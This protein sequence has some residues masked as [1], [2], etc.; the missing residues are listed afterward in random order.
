MSY[1]PIMPFE[2]SEAALRALPYW[3]TVIHDARMPGKIILYEDPSQSYFLREGFF[4]KESSL[5]K[6]QLVEIARADPKIG[7]NIANRC[8]E[9]LNTFNQQFDRGC[10][11]VEHVRNIR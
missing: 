10:P 11:T 7:M 9:L 4:S 2:D 3:L 6:S 1:E 5:E 8:I